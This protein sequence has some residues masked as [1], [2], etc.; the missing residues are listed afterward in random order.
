MSAAPAPVRPS[1]PP[2]RTNVLLITIDSLRADMP[3]A[4]YP[5]DIAPRLTALEKRC[6]SYTRAYA[7]ASHTAPSVGSMLYGRYASELPRDGYFSARYPPSLRSFV[8]ALTDAGVRTMAGHAHLY[9]QRAGFGRGFTTFELLPGLVPSP[10][11][12]T[13]LS[14]KALEGLAE[15]QLGAVGDHA[16]DGEPPFFAWYHF[17]DPHGEWLEAPRDE[18]VPRFGSRHRDRYDAEVFYTDKYVGK[19]LDYVESRP[20]GAHTLVIVTSDHGEGVG[21]HGQLYHGYEVWES[22]VHVPLFVCEPGAEPRHVDTPRSLIDLGATVLDAFDVPRPPEF[23]GSSWLPE[24]RGGPVEARD[25]LV[26]LPANNLSFSRRALVG[27][28]TKVVAIG[29]SHRRVVYDLVADPRERSPI[30]RGPVFDEQS[31]KLTEIEGTLKEV[32]PSACARGCIQGW[33]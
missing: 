18:G 8:A 15:R 26:D 9:L 13:S 27:E 14:S 32:A 24:V 30:R 11:L 5:R 4:G 12:D 21:D 25:V 31:S 3:W 10:N 1:R 6:T 22:L 28:R 16:G 33:Y 2:P 20:W 29:E 17:L 19:L 7:T 23:R